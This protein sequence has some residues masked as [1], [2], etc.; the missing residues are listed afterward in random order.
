ML[1]CGMVITS[2]EEEELL[3]IYLL[4]EILIELRK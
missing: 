3:Y 2:D 4:M 1:T